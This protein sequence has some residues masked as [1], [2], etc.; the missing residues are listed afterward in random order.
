MF[1]ELAASSH[2]FA[3]NHV[4]RHRGELWEGSAFFDVCQSRVVTSGH[5]V[6]QVVLLHLE[7]V[8]K[9][10]RLARPSPAFRH[11]TTIGVARFRDGES[12]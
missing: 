2:V 11:E 8:A 1:G 5:C 6:V 10:W 4:G 7:S 3:S 9:S 12:I